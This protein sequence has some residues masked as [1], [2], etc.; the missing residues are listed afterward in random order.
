MFHQT[1]ELIKVDKAVK[2]LGA[3]SAGGPERAVAV[4]IINRRH[5]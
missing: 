2:Q 4:D 3:C 5:D 1:S